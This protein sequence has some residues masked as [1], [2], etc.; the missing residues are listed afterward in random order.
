MTIFKPILFITIVFLIFS[1]SNKENDMERTC[2]QVAHHYDKSIDLGSD[3]AIV[4]GIN[5]SLNER[6][7]AWRRNGYIVHLMTG[8]AWGSYQDYLYGR[9]DGEEHL[10]DAQMAQNGNRV[11]H[12]GDVYYMV[13]TKPFT[14]YLKSLLKQALD[15]GVEA[16]YMEEPEFWVRSGYSESFKREWKDFYG[17]DWVDPESSED[18][19]Y[20]ASKLKQFLYFRAI[21]ELALYVKNYSEAN[22]KKIQFYIP[23]HSLINYAHWRIVSPESLLLKIPNLDGLIAQVWTGTSRTP[24]L[25]KGV[26][27]ERT[28]E[29]ALMEYGYFA[30]LIR[31]TGKKVWF[32]HDPVEDNPN[33]SWSDYRSNY[34]KT[35]VASLFYPEV[36]SYEVMPWP[37]R[38]FHGQ[39]P[40]RKKGDEWEKSRIPSKYAT[41]VL[42]VISTLNNMKQEDVEWDLALDGVGMLVSDTMMFQKPDM[43]SFY[44][45]VLPLL[46]AGVFVQ[47]VPMENFNA[48][49]M[50]AS[51]LRYMFL[52]YFFLKPPLEKVHEEL[53]KWVSEGGTLFYVD[54]M[55][56]PYNLVSEWWKEKGYESPAYD[57]FDQ[58]GIERTGEGDYKVGKG[59]FIFRKQSPKELAKREDGA[60]FVLNLLKEASEYKEQNYLMLRRGPYLIAAV[61]DESISK[62]PLL[63]KGSYIDIFDPELPIV[64]SKLVNPGE[65]AL[66]YDLGKFDKSK[67]KVLV[68]ASRIRNENIQGNVFTFLSLGPEG[69][70]A[71]A[72]IFL[73][74]KPKSVKVRTFNAKIWDFQNLWDENSN[75]LLLTYENFPDGLRIEVK[76]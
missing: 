51:R 47:P 8:I 16:I 34:E 53:V 52:S 62:E 31:G 15:S 68:S 54:D 73:P 60:S 70:T 25:F 69:V 11:S 37:W 6:V 61:M 13:P 56:D 41:E 44:G 38:V 74:S 42:T 35:V 46:K 45:I 55:Q 49:G 59:R 71:K 26:A 30:N 76:F 18:A 2:F 39:Y 57:L 43:S 66:L 58:L 72:R 63:L 75:T 64:E 12:G 50:Q 23:T 17:T 67:P 28:F 33:H 27:K 22:D 29:T 9:F 14:E 1:L 4:Y 7:T 19:S 21:R 10:D 40:F 32:L 65:V 48:K 20:K 5:P 24:N 36:S 3:V